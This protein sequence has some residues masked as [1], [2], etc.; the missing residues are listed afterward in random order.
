M[1][2]TL[3]NRRRYLTENEVGKL[4]R[5]LARAVTVGATLLYC[6]SWFATACV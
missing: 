1:E 2:R 4:L 3:S 5:L 6:F